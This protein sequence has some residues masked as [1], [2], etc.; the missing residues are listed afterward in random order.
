MIYVYE[1]PLTGEIKEIAQ[2]INEPHEYI[3]DGIKWHRVF[4]ASAPIIATNP[5]S[6]QDFVEKTNK[7]SKI[8]EIWDRAKDLSAKRAKQNGGVDPIK[9]KYFKDYALK[10]HGKKHIHDRL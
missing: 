7:K 8:G 5:N 10:R 9:T 4:T 3:E 6:I 1:H 2:G